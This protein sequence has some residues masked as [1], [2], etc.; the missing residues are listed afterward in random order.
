MGYFY[1]K[2]K[3]YELKIHEGVMYYGNEERCKI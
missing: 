1:P 2:Y 3:M